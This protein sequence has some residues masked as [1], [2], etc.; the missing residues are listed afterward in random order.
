MNPQRWIQYFE[1]H[2]HRQ[3]DE[4]YD[5]QSPP[6]DAALPGIRALAASLAIFQLGETGGGSRLRAYARRHASD[7]EQAVELF[8]GEEHGHAELLRKMV[9]RLGGRLL[10]KQWSNSIFR[11]IRNWIG[12]GFNIQVLLIAELIA[13]GYYGLLARHAPDA[14]IRA[15]CL[16]ITRDEAG[17]IAFHTDFFNSR[18]KTGPAWLA[19]AWRLQFRALF[20]VAR[21]VVWWDHGHALRQCGVTRSMFWEKTG[22]A[23]TAFLGGISGLRSKSA[24][25]DNTPV[26]RTMNTASGSAERAVI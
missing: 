16:R 1:T 15:V 6:P 25:P 20:R 9:L 8:I 19:A 3:A 22:R 12:L 5:W 24:D 26:F 13:R 18:Q 7:Y 11:R 23:R 21:L 2:H 17:H 4:T 10:E 14:V